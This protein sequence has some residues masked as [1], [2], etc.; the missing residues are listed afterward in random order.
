MHNTPVRF[1]YLAYL[2]RLIGHRQAYNSLLDTLQDQK[3]KTPCS[4]EIT[5]PLVR[6]DYPH[7]KFWTKQEWVNYSNKDV[8]STTDKTRG[9]SRAAQGV[10][11]TMRFAEIADGTVVD[12]HIAGNIRRCARSTWVHLANKGEAPQKWRS[13][14]MLV[15]RS[16]HDEMYRRFPF[17]QYCDDD[18]KAEQIAMDNYPSWYSSWCK[19]SSKA[20]SGANIK[21]EPELLV[22]TK[23]PNDATLDTETKKMKITPPPLAQPAAVTMQVDGF[24]AANL[25]TN[26]MV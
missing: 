13:A 21:D 4:T 16:Y 7:I 3:S 15:I 26:F 17:L 18:W 5:K 12:G 6:S 2:L 10:N 11:V 20:E 9:K 19:K 23:R 1:I 24:P 22:S 25:N 8:T 14:S